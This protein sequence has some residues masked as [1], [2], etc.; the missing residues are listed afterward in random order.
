MRVL[1]A[2]ERALLVEVADTPSALGLYERA[3]QSGWPVT[4][5]V[6]AARTVLFD[7]VADPPALA[8]ELA[9]WRLTGAQ[10]PAREAVE[11]PTVYDGADLPDVAQLWDMTAAE[12]VATHTKTAFTVAFCGFSPG[13]AYC[14]GLPESLRVPR[15]A[16]P[17]QRVPAGAVGLADVF[18]GVYPRSSPG[19]WQLIGSTSRQL[20]DLHADPPALLVPGTPVRFVEESS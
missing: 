1:P 16:S 18:T 7:G 13:F 11:L 9:T 20:W 6:P 8:A 4:D 10:P 12:V 15:R 17:R 2:G 19:G 5:L 14:T 3:R